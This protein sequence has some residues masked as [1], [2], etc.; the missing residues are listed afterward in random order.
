[1]NQQLK[2]KTTS[3]NA[4]SLDFTHN[5]WQAVEKEKKYYDI[6]IK[7]RE[8]RQKLG[9]TQDKLAEKAQLPR[10]TIVKVE[11][12]KRNA[13]LETLISMAQAMGKDLVLSLR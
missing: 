3:I 8:L 9:I 10:T 13:T 11:S 2:P 7:L 12:G 5:D 4:I 1:M 6:V